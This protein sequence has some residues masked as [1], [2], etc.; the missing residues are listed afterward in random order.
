MKSFRPY[1][2]GLLGKKPLNTKVV[3]FH[4]RWCEKAP[5]ISETTITP[6][7]LLKIPKSQEHRRLD[8][9]ASF[10]IEKKKTTLH[11]NLPKPSSN[12]SNL[13][14]KKVQSPLQSVFLKTTPAKT[15]FIH[16]SIGG[17]FMILRAE[18]FCF[19]LPF[20]RSWHK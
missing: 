19:P 6:S 18:N 1:E 11:L 12:I 5:Q 15:S 17:S 3:G 7:S 2:H 13:F 16:P 14:V 4:G 8:P 20:L 10:L 9:A